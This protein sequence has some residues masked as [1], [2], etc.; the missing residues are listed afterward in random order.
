MCPRI[1]SDE[2]FIATLTVGELRQALSIDAIIK[3]SQSSLAPISE[4]MT[5]D[6]VAMLLGLSKATLY[7]FT[8][9]RKIPYYKTAGGRK[10]YFNR[11]EIVEWLQENKTETVEQY[12]NNHINSLKK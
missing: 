4:I 3:A 9:E 8:H 5:I 11:A 12:C 2:T 10:L 7:R 6:E 1:I